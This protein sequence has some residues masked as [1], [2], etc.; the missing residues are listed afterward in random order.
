MDLN[1]D[2]E[3]SSAEDT[4]TISEVQI[5]PLTIMTSIPPFKPVD[6]DEEN[7]LQTM[8]PDVSQSAVSESPVSIS[9]V[10]DISSPT[11]SLPSS[12]LSSNVHTD[13]RSVA[14]WL[15]S[16]TTET[17]LSTLERSPSLPL[18]LIEPGTI[19]SRR[20]SNVSTI[21]DQQQSI[22]LDFNSSQ[23]ISFSSELQRSS[24]MPNNDQPFCKDNDEMNP[25]VN[26]DDDND[27]DGEDMS[28]KFLPIPESE[29]SEIDKKPEPIL[30][31]KEEQIQFE[32]RSPTTR[33]NPKKTPNVSFHA[34]I[35]FDTHLKPT[36]PHRRRRISWNANKSKPPLFQRSQS[37]IVNTPPPSLHAQI[38]RKQFQ[39]A[40]SMPNGAFQSG[41]N[42]SRQPSSLSD[43][44]FLSP[45]NTNTSSQGSCL[46]HS[47][48]N[49]FLPV[50][51]SSSVISSDRNQSIIS[52]AS[53]RS[54]IESTNLET[55]PSEQF[56][57]LSIDEDTSI[58]RKVVFHHQQR[59]CSVS[60]SSDETPST[61]SLSSSDDEM[62]VFN[63]KMKN[64]KVDKDTR[65]G[66]ID[67][68][69][70]VLKQLMWLLEKKA[71]ISARHEYG[72]RTLP[73]PKQIQ[74]KST[75]NSFAEFCSSF[76]SNNTLNTTSKNEPETSSKTSQRLDSKSN[77]LM[78][79]MSYIDPMTQSYTSVRSVHSDSSATNSVT[80]FKSTPRTITLSSPRKRPSH[81]RYPNS[82]PTNTRDHKNLFNKSDQPNT[83]PPE[84]ESKLSSTRQIEN[85]LSEHLRFLSNSSFQANM[86]FSSQNISMRDFIQARLYEQSQQT[87]I[88]QRYSNTE[89]KT[90]ID[91][92]INFQMNRSHH[93]AFLTDSVKELSITNNDTLHVVNRHDDDD[94]DK[95]DH[96][97]DGHVA[98][99]ESSNTSSPSLTRFISVESKSEV[100]SPE[101]RS[102]LD[103][104]LRFFRTLSPDYIRDCKQTE[105]DLK[106]IFDLADEQCTFFCLNHINNDQTD[107]SLAIFH[108]RLDA[109]F[110]WFN[111]YYEL[112]IAVKK[113]SGI[114]RCD[115]CD[116]WP[117]LHVRSIATSRERKAKRGDENSADFIT[118]SE[119]S[120]DDDDDV[121]EEIGSECES[122]HSGDSDMLPKNYWPEQPSDHSS[123]LEDES[124]SNTA[125]P[126]ISKLTR[127][128]CYQNFVDY[129]DERSYLVK[130]DGLARTLIER[131]A[132]VLIK[133]RLALLQ[134]TDQ[135]KAKI[136]QTIVG[137]LSSDV[138]SS[139]VNI[140]CNNDETE[141]K[142]VDTDNPTIENSTTDINMRELTIEKWLIHVLKAC[143]T[144]K[145]I[146]SHTDDIFKHNWLELHQQLGLPS[147]LPLYFFINNVL[148][149]VMNECLRLYDK[150]P[151]NSDAVEIDSLCRQQ[152]VRE[153]KLI[154]RDALATRLYSIRMME[155]FVSHRLL[156][157]EL[158][159][160]DE[161]TNK[162]YTHYKQCLSTVCINRTFGAQ[163][164]EDMSPNNEGNLIQ[165]HFVDEETSEL[166]KEYYFSR[167][168]TVT[169]ENRTEIRDLCLDFCAL[170][171]RIFDQLREILNGKTEKYYQVFA[172][173][174]G[175]ASNMNDGCYS[176]DVVCE[177]IKLPIL[178]TSASVP[179]DLTH[180]ESTL[181]DATSSFSDQK[182]NDIISSTREFR[183]E[184][185]TIKQRV[186]R[187]CHLAKTLIDD[188]SIAVEFKCLN[189]NNLWQQLRQNSYTQVK[190]FINKYEAEDFDN[191]LIFVPPWLSTDKEQVEKLLSMICTQQI[192]FDEINKDSPPLYMVFVPKKHFQRQNIHWHGDYLYIQPSEITK[193]TLNLTELTS[194]HLVVNRSDQWT[195]AANLFHSH[196]GLTNVQLIRKLPRDEGIRST[197]DQLPEYIEKLSTE[198]TNLVRTLNTIWDQDSTKIYLTEIVKFD[199]RTIESK[200]VDLVLYVYSSGFDIFRLLYDLIPN[201]S[202]KND[203]DIFTNFVKTMNEFFCEWCRC[204][205][206]KF[207]YISGQQARTAKYKV[208]RPKWAAPGLVFLRFLAKS[209]HL[210]L[211]S[212]ED[213]KKLLKE[214]PAAFD[215]LYGNVK[216]NS[217]SP[218]LK[219][220]SFVNECLCR[221]I[222]LV[223]SNSSSSNYI[224]RPRNS[225]SASGHHR[226]PSGGRISETITSM[227]LTPRERIAHKIKKLE[228]ELEK[229]FRERKLIGRIF[230]ATTLTS[231]ATPDPVIS[232]KTRNIDFPWRRGTR[233]GQGGAGVAFRAINSS[234]GSIVCMKE[235]LL[236]SI[237]SRSLP[238]V[239]PEK[240]RGIAE[241]IDMIMSI[242]HPNIV[243]YF[244][245]ER[246][247]RTIYICM[248]YCLSTV[249]EF[250]NDIRAFQKRAHIKRKTSVFW[251]DSS[252]Q[253]DNLSND[254]K[255]FH[256]L[257]D[258]N[259]H[260]RGFVKQ[261]LNALM[262]LH[263]NNIVH[264][265][266]KGDNIFIANEDGK[267][268]VK[269]GDFNLSHRLELQSAS[270]NGNDARSTQKGTIYFKPPEL[271][272]DC[273][274]DIWALGCTIIE[275]LTGK[276][277]WT[278]V[279]RPFDA[280]YIQNQ[281][282]AKKG[283]PIPDELKPQ[284]EA[285]EF[286]ELCLKA[287]LEERRSARELLSHAYP[288]VRI[289]S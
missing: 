163:E 90:F 111:L 219:D 167:D 157:A 224:G 100:I 178:H 115:D 45:S 63:I 189:Y 92:I 153:A 87:S 22:N 169:L 175:E 204:V 1:A 93:Y 91:L 154:L 247:K 288:R 223:R 264:C 4:P 199:E 20:G 28:M 254:D 26:A 96:S 129:M 57:S 60:T 229:K 24:S 226:V 201:I 30:I 142:L 44:V 134:K 282:L 123:H 170:T 73:T 262:V 260:V 225:S 15:E 187:V 149:D 126:P 128:A 136:G 190:I 137:F 55:T 97:K 56:Q 37:S 232:L 209:T 231:G 127:N 95:D 176:A 19:R 197:F 62:D 48:N 150:P 8:N 119:E 7:I 61:Q 168:L 138:P 221:N 80:N 50:P 135:Q 174:M 235:I 9:L 245:I 180:C 203:D 278:N 182:K 118:T 271:V 71:I 222:G 133:T 72:H 160:F 49:R 40:L 89:M 285:Y 241:E 29:D 85:V 183:R 103:H 179:P 36:I 32:G 132:P 212:D 287:D 214:M 35:S 215:A 272:Y 206:K 68:R 54:G 52:D 143:P 58:H 289:S 108:Q 263:E 34:S 240:L 46:I 82:L 286:I 75:T 249:N 27:N 177:S 269:L 14:A 239:Y 283:P 173:D 33:A 261:L 208:F 251:S 193:L 51:S 144:I 152:L 83:P 109:L 186:T 64:L 79:Q 159:E 69:R 274:S 275:M 166:I 161:N 218:H 207:K 124:T 3:K 244:G 106:K 273:K 31:A 259:E 216:D 181:S 151:I 162:L 76:R 196:I 230:D 6:D 78:P 67:K 117:K 198:L 250:L 268:I 171:Q 17:S 18:T 13:N 213:Y 280:I 257:L 122:E 131:V 16:S 47:K 284:T 155:H 86:S 192:P 145:T 185:D 88:N 107:Q 233:I 101:H 156:I 98:S 42:T 210:Q 276:L 158:T 211:L 84:Q 202:P 65:K 125:N 53:G 116:D 120:D 2:E 191:F 217:N 25:S 23:Q 43:N 59:T 112:T 248:E 39:T 195:Q 164:D 270:T 253:E 104:P 172:I 256:C 140:Q 243:R 105:Y 74:Q 228:N 5:N 130:Y 113:L 38:L 220:V 200:L 148:L 110:V 265:D 266:V 141:D 237:A 70:N 184:F 121:D 81:R 194:L 146:I 279:T 94:D 41:S 12:S 114:L 102:F 246:Y 10:G 205:T 255:G 139:K 147:L 277:P 188:F 258:V 238:N 234:N 11:I 21:C 165:Y 99:N 77:I 252:E 242:N 281:L 236:S 227:M 66:P 267:Y